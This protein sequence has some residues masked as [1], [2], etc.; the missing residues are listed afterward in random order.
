MCLHDKKYL[1]HFESK[2]KL[3][4]TLLAVGKYYLNVLFE[5]NKNS[6]DLHNI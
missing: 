3:K 4:Y 6:S 2:S 5:T 1:S